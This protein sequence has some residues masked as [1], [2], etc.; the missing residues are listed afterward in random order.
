[1]TWNDDRG[2]ADEHYLVYYNSSS[3]DILLQVNRQAKMW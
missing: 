2:A 3:Q 1:M